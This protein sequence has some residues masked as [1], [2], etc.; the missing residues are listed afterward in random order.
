MWGKS[1]SLICIVKCN[2]C[3][4]QNNFI[5]NKFVIILNCQL[6]ISSESRRSK[7]SPDKTREQFY[8]K[9]IFLIIS[10]LKIKNAH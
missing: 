8:E 6:P 4:I 2:I 1:S 5:F 7:Y 10:I 9:K 3:L